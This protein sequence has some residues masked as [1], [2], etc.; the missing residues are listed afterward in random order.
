MNKFVKG[1]FIAAGILMV[2]GIVFCLISGAV[3][4]INALHIIK[5]DAY[6][7]G[8]L[9]TAEN[10]F[11]SFADRITGGGWHHNWGTNPTHLTVNGKKAKA[12][13]WEDRISVEDIRNLELELGAGD[14][15]IR[16]KEAA[17]G[18]VDITIEGVG[19]CNY[20]VKD[21]T[22]HLEGFTGIKTFGTNTNK[23]IFT[24]T[25]PAG[26]HFNEAD[27]E[28]G[29]GRME[30]ASLQAEEVSVQ[31]GAGECVMNQVEAKELSADIG[32]GNFNAN[33]MR[34]QDLSLAVGMGECFY[35]GA[36]END[37]NAE[38]GMGN[39]ELFLNGEESDYNY[40]LECSAGNIDI[41][42]SSVS[43]LA[44]ERTIQNGASKTI[45]LEC[46]M[47]NISIYFNK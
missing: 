2:V 35:E 46:S 37:L 47:G 42:G 4:G 39:I 13:V 38:C 11:E 30:L 15:Y 17:D 27:I 40:E 6:L 34:A 16:E 26:S 21:K 36:V 31:I 10:V 18:M 3:G 32:A 28:I 8:K 24:L 9:E 22:L 33:Q 44:A 19:G 25:F 43:A 7:D 23:N 12:E 5:N 20:R 1:S 45:E 14:F 41:N 29:A